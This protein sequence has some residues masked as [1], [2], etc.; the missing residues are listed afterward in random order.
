M[1]A[2]H[3]SSLMALLCVSMPGVHQQHLRAA[4]CLQLGQPWSEVQ[5]SVHLLRAEPASHS[6][7]CTCLHT[8]TIVKDVQLA[9]LTCTSIQPKAGSWTLTLVTSICARPAAISPLEEKSA[10]RLPDRLGS[11]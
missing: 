11:R 1:H 6:M 8:V 10:V 7:A 2:L 4:A 9:L 3:L 5:A